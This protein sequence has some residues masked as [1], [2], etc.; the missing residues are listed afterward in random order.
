[1]PTKLK[2]AEFLNESRLLFSW[3]S[4]KWLDK[5]VHFCFMAGLLPAGGGVT[6]TKG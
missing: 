2:Y 3:H 4:F 1:M 6:W 5:S